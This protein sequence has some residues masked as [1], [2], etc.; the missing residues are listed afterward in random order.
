MNPFANT[1]YNIADT[2]GFIVKDLLP[3]VLSAALCCAA[4]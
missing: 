2:Q 1:L 4:S 3:A